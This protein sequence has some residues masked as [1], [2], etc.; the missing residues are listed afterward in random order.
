M[1]QQNDP[2]IWEQDRT[3]GDGGHWSWD[4]GA[5]GE[6]RGKG[7]VPNETPTTAPSLAPPTQSW[8]N[9][10]KI[11]KPPNEQPT[12]SQSTLNNLWDKLPSWVKG[13]LETLESK[14]QREIDDW[15][16]YVQQRE[17]ERMEDKYAAMMHNN[18]YRQ[19]S[20]G[21]YRIKHRKFWNRFTRRWE[22]I[23]NY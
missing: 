10:T 1:V 2:S 4:I 13:N 18:F 15:N 7:W 12:P 6:V 17:I 23:K 22:Y 3:E 8:F 19:K 20:R 11:P 16:R 9:P 14:T 21:N 5:G